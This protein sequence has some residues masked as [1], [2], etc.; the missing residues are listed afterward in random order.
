ML[1]GGAKSTSTPFD[2]MHGM[3]WGKVRF[4]VMWCVNVSPPTLWQAK[5]GLQALC[6]ANPI[7]RP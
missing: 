3:H 2:D 5:I 1:C 7:T 4:Y 6:L